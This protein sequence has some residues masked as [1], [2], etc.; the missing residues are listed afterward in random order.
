MIRVIKNPGL[1]QIGHFLMRR[2][3]SSVTQDLH[4]KRCASSPHANI[5]SIDCSQQNM[6][7]PFVT[8]AESSG[9]YVRSM[10]GEPGVG[11]GAVHCSTS[12]TMGW[13]VE[14]AG[15]EMVDDVDV[16]VVV[17]NMLRDSKPFK[18]I[19][20]ECWTDWCWGALRAFGC[21]G[22]TNVR[23]SRMIMSNVRELLMVSP[24]MSQCQK[25]WYGYTEFQKWIHIERNPSP[26]VK[27]LEM[28]DESN[29]RN[30]VASLS[31]K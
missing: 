14:I 11:S 18:S 10:I 3:T 1:R 19:A 7:T 20:F 23:I 27:K 17:V 2:F 12:M 25:S 13:G 22:A 29:V 8:G 26:S 15:A 24:G 9:T 31:I 21:A 30:I 5:T 4:T 6:H 28:R 16:V